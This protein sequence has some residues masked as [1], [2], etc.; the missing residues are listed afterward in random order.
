MKKTYITERVLTFKQEEV[1]QALARVYDL[2]L[3][4]GIHGMQM[5]SDGSLEIQTVETGE[6]EL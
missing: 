6:V 4:V 1:Y 5:L 2:T 3:D